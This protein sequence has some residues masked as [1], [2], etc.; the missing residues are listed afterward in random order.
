LLARWLFGSLKLAAGMET[1]YGS[2]GNLRPW[3]SRRDVNL[4]AIKGGVRRWSADGFLVQSLYLII[5]PLA[6]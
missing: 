4:N 3:Q 2:P 5:I 6:S 1:A